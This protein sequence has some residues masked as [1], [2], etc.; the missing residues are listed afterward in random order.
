MVLLHI[1]TYADSGGRGLVPVSLGEDGALTPGEPFAGAANASFA[2]AGNGL[3]YAVDEGEEGALNVLRREGERWTR[4]ARVPSGGAAPC[5][6][7]LSPDG[8]RLALANYESGSVVL[9]SLGSDGLPLGPPALFRNEGKG[10]NAERQE[11]PHAHCVRFAADG[12]ALYLVDLGADRVLR[13]PLLA[14][15]F[16][17][18][19]VAWTAPA[20]SGPRHM[21]FHPD[22]RRA[23]LLS[24]LAAALTLLE[25]GPLGLETRQT[26]RT[27]PEGFAGEN[28]G[29]HLALNPA[30]T[31]VYASNRGH[32]SLAVFAL[33]G[34]LELLQH[35]PSGGAHPRHFA[36]L[37]ETGQLVAA[38]EK[39][40]CVA[41]FD[42]QADGRLRP[43]GHRVHVPGAC[44]V[45]G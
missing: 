41:S 2:V 42:L 4:L 22:G 20:G 8:R 45:L 11:G 5:Y 18:A 3:V 7:A 34:D 38:H 26:V 44:F 32:D 14:E 1:G 9:Y 40:G 37:R 33:D 39:D 25:F 23:V 19:E 29:G 30:G 10:A 17:A 16:G 12:S 24:E 21:L 15:G 28:L 31:R 27:A 35:V 6:V 36:L 13:L 43:T